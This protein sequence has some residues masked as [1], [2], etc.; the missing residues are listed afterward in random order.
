MCFTHSENAK[1]NDSGSVPTQLSS[2]SGKRLEMSRID[3]ILMRNSLEL[4][5]DANRVRLAIL[6]AFLCVDQIL[7][8]RVCANALVKNN[9]FLCENTTI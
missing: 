1:K 4:G 3:L 6:Y 5:T 2:G 8:R 7:V 9:N